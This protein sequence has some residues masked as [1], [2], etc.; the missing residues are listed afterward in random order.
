MEDVRADRARRNLEHFGVAGAGFDLSNLDT[1]T[2]EEIQAHLLQ[3]VN[4]TRERGI[5]YG[6]NALSFL[7]DN[8][9][10]F[11]KLASLGSGGIPDGLLGHPARP[12]L[13]NIRVM[14]EYIRIG[15]ESG[16]YNEFRELQMRGM[17][18]AQ[19]LEVVM[20]AQLSG[21]G[22]RSMGHVHNAVGKSLFDWRDGDGPTFPEGWAPDPAAFQA[23]LDLSVGHLTEQDRASISKVGTRVDNWLEATEIGALCH[24]AQSALSEVPAGEVGGRLQDPSEAGR[25]VHDAR[26][27]HRDRLPRGAPREAALLAKAWGLTPGLGGGA[28]LRS[29]VLTS[30]ASKH[31]KRCATT[32][33][34]TFWT[35]GA[36]VRLA[37]AAAAL[38]LHLTQGSIVAELQSPGF[39]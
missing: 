12:V 24:Q 2:E 19:I 6:L 15:W 30:E 28:D 14:A 31:S 20:Y 36:N 4:Y 3:W 8:R 21:G 27:A 18:K 22:I 11:A 16:I 39:N 25:A 26:A 23:G 17:S 32:R 7:A 29:G 35:T 5:Y 37:A 13:Q 10:D 38:E 34:T 33:S 9:P 1:T